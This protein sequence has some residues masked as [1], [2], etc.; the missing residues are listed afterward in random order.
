MTTFGR[1]MPAQVRN[2][3]NLLAAD[4]IAMEQYFDF[5]CNR[6]FRKTLL[7]R[8]EVAVKRSLSWEALHGL[9]VATNLQP[10]NA[11]PKIADNT[12]ETFASAAGDA[13][14]SANP[15][16]K[17][18]FCLLGRIWPQS[19]RFEA[20]VQAASECLPAALRS[21]SRDPQ[22]VGEMLLQGF[23]STVVHFSLGPPALLA[24][25]SQRPQASGISRFQAGRAQSI[26]NRKHITLDLDEIDRHVLRR[27]DGTRD[28]SALLAALL[29]DCQKGLPVRN[30]DGELVSDR[31]GLEGLLD[32]ALEDSLHRLAS[33][34]F[35]I[36]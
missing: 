17:A 32:Q 33:K 28:R 22:A 16:I 27:L 35:L 3:L 30:P 10:K 6:A 7:C 14:S 21:A 5:L 15:V 9:H 2:T 34:A 20:L 29:E 31:A 25:V 1:V 11:E 36:A 4:L 18:A 19:I 23:L 8:Q 13:L 26:T 12:T 24:T